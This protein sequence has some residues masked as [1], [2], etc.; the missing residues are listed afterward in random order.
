[1]LQADDKDVLFRKAGDQWEVV[2]DTA[3]VDLLDDRTEFRLG[4]LQVYS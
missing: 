3:K 4:R 1:L 2:P